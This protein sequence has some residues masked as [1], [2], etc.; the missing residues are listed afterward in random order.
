MTMWQTHHIA[1]VVTGL[2]I[3]TLC[4]RTMVAQAALRPP[5]ASQCQEARNAMQ[6]GRAAA[7]AALQRVAVDACPDGATI[8]ATFLRSVPRQETDVAFL[9]FATRQTDRLR[10]PEVF[11]AALPLAQ[12]ASAALPARAAGLLMIA[13]AFGP[14]LELNRVTGPAL[15]LEPRPEGGCYRTALSA[16]RGGTD[17][18]LSSDAARQAARVFDPLIYSSTA[19]LLLQRLAGCLR[20]AV[21]SDIPPQLDVSG[22]RLTYL[23]GTRFRVRNPLPEFLPMSYDVYGKNEGRGVNAGPG[24]TVFSTDSVGTV[25]LFYDGRLIQTKANGNVACRP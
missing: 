3:A 12:D 8:L 15:L 6:A 14:S 19:P 11:A 16:H 23:C 7:V 18:P 9:W 22:V 10:H 1:R 13:N 2:A 24:D 17:R 5:T 25:R 4:S 20:S 21:D